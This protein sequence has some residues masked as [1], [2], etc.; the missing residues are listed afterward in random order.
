MSLVGAESREQRIKQAQGYEVHAKRLIVAGRCTLT[1]AL[2]LAAAFSGAI[3]AAAAP[4]EESVRVSPAQSV[5]RA[6]AAAPYGSAAPTAAPYGTAPPTAVAQ[7]TPYGAAPAPAAA[8]GGSSELF[9]QVQ[10]LQQE[11]AELRGLVEELTHQVN[12]LAS[13][14]Q[15]QYRDLD[16]R[17]VALRGGAGAATGVPATAPA[18]VAGNIGQTPAA[19]TATPSGQAAQP[20]AG[21]PAQQGD[22]GPDRDA[23]SAAFELMRARKFPEATAAF[24]RFVRD[25]PNS[26]YT[27]NAFYWLGELHLAQN[28]FEPARQS[29]MQVVN[30][31]PDSQKMPDALYKLGV[32]HHRIGDPVR[33]REYLNRAISQFPSAPAAALAQTYLAELQ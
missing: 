28:A 23:Y 33:A 32:V 14:Q 19:P 8:A 24:D 5:Y 7:A 2:V 4:V 17:V 25:Y 29:F 3:A 12:R 26:G 15:A 27:A 18:P 11:V 10:S 1:G 6:P 22:A 16:A 9:M 20:P 13:D 21:A 30:L 31:Y